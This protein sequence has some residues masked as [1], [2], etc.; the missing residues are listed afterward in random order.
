MRP[1]KLAT[2]LLYITFVA[3]VISFLHN[4][5]TSSSQEISKP[6]DFER[7]IMPCY[8]GGGASSSSLYGGQ[9]QQA[10]PLAQSPIS[11]PVAPYG[12]GSS[13]GPYSNQIGRTNTNGVSNGNGYQPT[14][15]ASSE[16]G[17]FNNQ[18]RGSLSNLGQQVPRASTMDNFIALLTKIEAANPRLANNP[19]Q[20]IRALLGRFRMDNYY[21][22]VRSRTPIGEQDHRRE[23]VQAILNPTGLGQQVPQPYLIQS[24]VFPEHLL[25]H[26]EKCSMYFMLSHFI[27]KATPLNQ[28]LS[29]LPVTQMAIGPNSRPP[30]L[31]A[32]GTGYPAQSANNAFSGG[33][34]GSRYP[35]PSPSF[36]SPATSNMNAFGSGLSNNPDYTGSNPYGANVLQPNNQFN[37]NY[38]NLRNAG[39]YSGTSSSN[40]KYSVP[41]MDGNARSRD[42]RQALEYGVV[43][44]GN[45]ENAALVL[46]R[47]LM[48]ILAA[49]TPP[50]TIRQLAAVIYPTQTS[51]GSF[52]VDEE[53]DPLFAV[54][55]A[56]LW[57]V[58]SIP[59]AGKQFDIKL[60]GD[61]GRWNGTMC[62]TSFVLDRPNSI[63]FTTAEMIGGLDG[64]NLGMFRR[65]LMSLRKSMRLS[66]IFKMYYSK[67][68]F[69]PQFAEVGVCNRASG[70]NTQLDDLRRQAEN[71][72]RLYQLN[73]PIGDAEIANSINRLDSFKELTRQAANQYTP[74]EVCQDSSFNDPYPLS[75]QDQCEI[76]KADVSI[77]LDTSPQSNDEFM[78]VV[79]V[80]LAQK[81][82]L[83]R[84]GNSLSIFTNQQDSTGYAGAFSFN[85][86]VRNSTNTA[87]IGCSLVHDTTRSYQGGQITDPTRL[88]EMFERALITLDSEYLIR[89]S[90]NSLSTSY[91]QSSY[92]SSLFGQS[93]SSFYM[94]GISPRNT[95]GAKVIIWFNYG[96]QQ[97]QSPLASSPTNWNSPSYAD[98][99]YKF[100]EAKRYLRE[101]YRGASIL[102]V[103]NNREDSKAFVYD[104]DKDIFTDIPPGSGGSSLSDTYLT[105]SDPS[106]TAALIGPADQLVSKLLQR[107]CD[108]PAVFQYPMCFRGPSDNVIS[109]GYISPGRKQYW[110]MSPKTFFASRSVRMVFKAEGGRL[111]VCFGRMPKPD[112]S[113]QKYGQQYQTGGISLGI[114]SGDSTGVTG[115]ISSDDYYTGLKYGICK[116]VSSAQEIDFVVNEPCYKK[117]IAE[118]EPFYYVIKE[119]SNPGEIDPNYMCKD[120]G[121]Q[122]FDQ[123]KFTMSHTG[124]I[125]SS[126]F[127]SASANWLLITMSIGFSI[128]MTTKPLNLK[129]KVLNPMVKLSLSKVVPL[130][131]VTSFLIVQQSH[132]QQAGTY[133]FGLP[134]YGEKRGN[135]TP[136]EILAII[137]LI[138]TVIAGLALTIG[139]CYYVKKR[140]RGMTRVD[141]DG[142]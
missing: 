65:R 26:D 140:S 79:A 60:L 18:P 57:A 71:Y 16:S 114:G 61:N 34:S 28:P 118:C 62:P 4:G 112:E 137:L 96:S 47:V 20:L 51:L 30:V 49:T 131:A 29:N 132:A 102:A 55:L 72:L 68:G 115:Q 50:Q 53:I 101:N 5:I 52:K 75:Q 25:N 19:D 89:Q 113:A 122:R 17:R 86:I 108:I 90:Q 99:Q 40:T 126:A 63:T 124:V 31:Q 22:D 104:E 106:S 45:Q 120:E 123:A 77:V 39:Q 133:D 139:L 109:V 21:Y 8:L 56:D 14:Y 78:N 84:Q 38:N 74:I 23:I 54:T 136:S 33:A 117:S 111:K 35:G 9:T 13:S 100:Q 128:V 3:V 127:R 103:S 48:G 88:F 85:A 70:I 142:Y 82:G 43:T 36:G 135:F 1:R 129:Q 41:Y 98:N 46:N 24:D 11:S 12:M 73:L 7:L 97:R 87:E 81:L 95:G 94:N 67:N 91:R 32:A 110:M 121:C 80:R 141:Q 83:S 27:D 42:E 66:E 116:D 44:V 92:V 6:T 37:Q 15:F 138:M 69:R 93:D 58:S 107:M 64:F 10:D 76:S 59:K 134:R 119:I 125:C 105:S 130:A 2:N